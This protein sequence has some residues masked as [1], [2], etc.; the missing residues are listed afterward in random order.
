MQERA[1]GFT[2]I[3]FIVAASLTVILT[4][5]ASAMILPALRAMTLQSVRDTQTASI[6]SLV[7]QWRSDERSAWAIF[8]P[9]QDVNGVSND[10]GHELDMFRRDQESRSQFWA[11]RFDETAHAVTRYLYSDIG[12]NPVADETYAGITSFSARTYPVTALSDPSSAIYSPLFKGVGLTPASVRFFGDQH[13]E[14]AGGNQITHVRVATA[15]TVRDLLLATES[16]PS[17]FTIVLRYTP[18]PT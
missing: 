1:R 12:S 16:A 6:E 4:A 3:E 5:I 11:Y 8:T 14:V 15:V 9:A 17:G 18:S 7:D 10:D 13:P 2:L